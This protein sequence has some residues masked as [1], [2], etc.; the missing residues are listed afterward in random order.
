MSQDKSQEFVT[1]HF[2]ETDT[3]ELL[4]LM[5]NLADFEDYLDEF[6]VAQSDLI[7]RGLCEEP[8]FH[9]LVAE[10]KDGTLL[11]MAVYYTIPFIHD[12]HPAMVLKELYVTDKARGMGVGKALMTGVKSAAKELKCKR[13]KWL[14]LV[15]NERA[16]K[17]YASQ[18]G[19]QDH[20][21]ENWYLNVA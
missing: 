19:Q 3:N 7:E 8:Q 17:F 18:G 13:I 5:R 12:L 10:A 2:T 15:G 20:K 16:R 11:G 6:K 14:V 1:R 9:A 21:W 4:V